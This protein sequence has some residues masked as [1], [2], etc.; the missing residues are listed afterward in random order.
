MSTADVHGVRVA[1]IIIIFWIGVWNLTEELV[2]WIEYNYMIERRKQY[3]FLVLAA[4]LF[5]ILDPYTFEKL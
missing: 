1:F 5:I 3:M 2:G 4:L